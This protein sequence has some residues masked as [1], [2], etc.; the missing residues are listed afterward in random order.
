[1]WRRKVLVVVAAGGAALAAFGLA[2]LSVGTKRV[3]LGLC[4]DHHVP[5]EHN[6]LLFRMCSWNA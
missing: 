1:M 2:R 4:G 5:A 6:N 3:H